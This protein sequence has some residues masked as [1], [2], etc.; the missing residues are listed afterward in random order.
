[1]YCF[2]PKF[3]QPHRRTG[4]VKLPL[5]H[6]ARVTVNIVNAVTMLQNMTWSDWIWCTFTAILAVL[7]ALWTKH[8][9][10]IPKILNWWAFIARYVLVWISCSSSQ[11]QW[12]CFL[13]FFYI[14]LGCHRWGE[15]FSCILTPTIGTD[16]AELGEQFWNKYSDNWQVKSLQFRIK[17][18]FN[19]AKCIVQN[20]N[21][22]VMVWAHWRP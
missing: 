20:R 18:K 7:T 5:Q 19:V 11:P 6:F 22:F 10:M 2:P 16:G 14:F 1:M 4:S 12:F 9:Y 21:V 15:I 3:P 17:Q 13:F 8:L